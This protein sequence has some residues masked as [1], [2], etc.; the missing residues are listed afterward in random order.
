MVAY[1]VPSRCQVNVE[2][3]KPAEQAPAQPVSPL[4]PPGAWATSSTTAPGIYAS[5]GGP[6]YRVRS[7]TVKVGGEG[8]KTTRG[9]PWPP[10]CGYSP[11]LRLVDRHAQPELADLART[12]LE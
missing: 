5:E 8:D 1:I 3:Q 4:A 11:F 7:W 10:S 2:R 6:Q 9:R 12:R